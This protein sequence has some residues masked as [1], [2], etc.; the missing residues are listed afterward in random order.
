MKFRCDFVTNSSSSSFIINK[1]C[2]T[3]NQIKAIENHET[4]GEKMG[5]YNFDEPW[6]IYQNEKYIKGSTFMDNF[7]MDSFLQKIDINSDR[8]HWGDFEFDFEDEECIDNK[9]WEDLLNEI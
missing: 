9:N 6:D 2:L 1:K 7:D 3:Q 4:L 5:M 8:V